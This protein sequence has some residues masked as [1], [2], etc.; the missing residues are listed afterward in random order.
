MW[1]DFWGIVFA[2]SLSLF[3]ILAVVVAVAGFKDVRTMFRR[4]REGNS[5]SKSSRDE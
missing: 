5:Q 3:A 1:G 4:L 2:I